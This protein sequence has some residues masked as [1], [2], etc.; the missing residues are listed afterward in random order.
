MKEFDGL[1]KILVITIDN[2]LIS[3]IVDE[4]LDNIKI[5]KKRIDPAPSVKMQIQ[6]ECVKG[7]GLIEERMII[8]LDLDQINDE[9]NKEIDH[10]RKQDGSDVI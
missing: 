9:I 7:V 6:K 1:T 5:E 10:F 8:I 2:I 3:F 4:I